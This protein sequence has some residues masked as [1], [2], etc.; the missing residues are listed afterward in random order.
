VRTINHTRGFLFEGTDV[1]QTAL[2]WWSVSNLEADPSGAVRASRPDTLI[3]VLSDMLWAYAARDGP[4]W[5]YM[6]FGWSVRALCAPGGSVATAVPWWRRRE[7]GCTQWWFE[8]V[9]LCAHAW[10]TRLISYSPAVLLCF[11]FNYRSTHVSEK[12]KIGKFVR[13]SCPC[14]AMCTKIPHAL[15]VED[16]R[17]VSMQIYQNYE[18]LLD[19]FSFWKKKVSSKRCFCIVCLCYVNII[20]TCHQHN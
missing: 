2:R 4:N 19:F 8:L 16:S 18:E 12:Q 6:L 5:T 20:C 3:L 15:G 7:Y 9:Y 14:K 17:Y 13:K 10:L 1:S 11:C